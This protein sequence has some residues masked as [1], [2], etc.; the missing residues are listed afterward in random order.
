[1][2]QSRGP[3]IESKAKAKAPGLTAAE[4]EVWRTWPGFPSDAGN[5]RG[6]SQGWGSG[7]THSL[8]V[9]TG[10]GFQLHSKRKKAKPAVKHFLKQ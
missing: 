4:T 6:A 7:R 3:E 9:V 1:M 8:D 10:W 5:K 2:K